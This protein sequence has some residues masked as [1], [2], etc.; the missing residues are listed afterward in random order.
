M[1]NVQSSMGTPLAV[2]LEQLQWFAEDVMSK[3]K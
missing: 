3:V 2:M 1:V